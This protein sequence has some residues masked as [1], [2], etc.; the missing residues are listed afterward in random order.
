M[1]T[2]YILLRNINEMPL[3]R[4]KTIDPSEYI[5]TEYKPT[6]YITNGR[7]DREFTNIGKDG[8]IFFYIRNNEKLALACVYNK[9]IK[10][11]HIIWRVSFRPVSI[12]L[13]SGIHNVLQ[14]DNTATNPSYIGVA[15]QGYI[16]LMKN[17]YILL[18]DDTHYLGGQGLWKKVARLS[19][20]YKIFVRILNIKENEF[21]KDR[22]GNIINYDGLNVPDEDIWK[23]VDAGKY[24]I[25]VGHL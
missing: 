8:D 23:E 6:S 4:N 22:N 17:G 2:P 10:E 16:A 13:P 11:Y 1:E 25:L 12:R 20:D 5:E 3:L 14:I 21:L 24:Y 9:K 7:L 19:K 18:S 15:S